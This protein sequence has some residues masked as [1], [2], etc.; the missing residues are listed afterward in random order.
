MGLTSS[1]SHNGVQRTHLAR[2]LG[3]GIESGDEWSYFNSEKMTYEER[4][5][6]SQEC[7]NQGKIYKIVTGAKIFSHKN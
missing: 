6:F 7:R 4:V 3:S 5:I 2:R 1:A